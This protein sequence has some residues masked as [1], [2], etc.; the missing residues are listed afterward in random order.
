MQ[1]T[2][3]TKTTP[4]TQPTNIGT[5]CLEIS[6]QTVPHNPSNTFKSP[7]NRPVVMGDMGYSA[8]ISQ[9]NTFGGFLIDRS[10]YTVARMSFSIYCS[11]SPPPHT[12]RV[13]NRSPHRSLTTTFQARK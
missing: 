1:S 6:L 5:N 13:P 4:S 11:C 10:D 3:S 2:D 9:P 12:S 7:K 8:L